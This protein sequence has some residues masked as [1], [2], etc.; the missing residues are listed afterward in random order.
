MS[1]RYLIGEGK[2]AYVDQE[3]SSIAQEIGLGRKLYL[4]GGG[5]LCSERA[6]RRQTLHDV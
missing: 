6:F 2:S 1:T 4:N 3:V 5:Q